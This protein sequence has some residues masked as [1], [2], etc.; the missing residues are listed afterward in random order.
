MM[1]NNLPFRLASGDMI[2]VAQPG[3]LNWDHAERRYAPGPR[4]NL[5]FRVIRPPD[6]TDTVGHR[7]AYC[8]EWDGEADTLECPV[9]HTRP[10]TPAE[11][12]AW[13]AKRAGFP[14]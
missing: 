1:I 8:E 2:V 13:H 6:R 12:R 11:V 14:R 4:W 9:E 3:G 5:T 10:A 7:R